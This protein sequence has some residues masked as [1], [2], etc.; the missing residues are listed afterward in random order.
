M[1]LYLLKLQV[2]SIN[3]LKIFEWLGKFSIK[4]D[5]KIVRALKL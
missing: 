3:K 4:T 5:N 2:L 1:E